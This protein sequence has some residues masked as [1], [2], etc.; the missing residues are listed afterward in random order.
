MLINRENREG[1]QLSGK[2]SSKFFMNA[3]LIAC[4]LCMVTGEGQAGQPQ[5]T[6]FAQRDQAF[7]KRLRMD[8]KGLFSDLEFRCVGPVVM[9]GRVVDVEPVPDEPYSFYVAYATGGL[10]KTENNGMR[11]KPVFEMQNAVSIGDIAV[12]PKCPDTIWVGTGEANSARSHYSGT[13]IFKTTDGGENW[14]CMGLQETH[15]VGRILVHPDDSNIIYVAAMGHLYTE[16]PERGVFKS[17]DGGENW[18]KILYLN[19]KT[20]AIDIIFD[21][22]NPD[23]IY[24]AMWQKVRRAWNIDECGPDSGIYKS[25]DGGENWNKLD[26]FPQNKYIGRIGLAV[27]PGNPKVV[28]AL[29]DNHKPKPQEEQLGKALISV[30]KLALMTRQDVLDVPESEL[31]SFIRRARLPK[32]HTAKEIRR[33]LTED[34]ITVKD[35]YDYLVRLDSEAI[36]PETYGAEVYRSDDKGDSWTKMNLT[37]LDS[38]Y[39]IAG[40]YFGQIR[41]SPD[42]EDRIYIMGVPLLASADG[43]RTY[44]S[45]GKSNVHVDHHAL[46]IDPAHPD[47]IINGNDGG[48]NITYD[49]GETWQKL[50]YVP[51]GQFYAINVDMA[52]PY[53]IY[54]GLQDNGT[55]KG[56]SRSVINESQPWEHISGG[57]GFYIQ[58]A[59]DFT[60]YAGSQWGHY[61]RMDTN[62]RRT[63]VRPDSPRMDEPGLR[64]NWQTPIMLSEHSSNVLY[65]GA[66]RLFRSLDRGENLKPISPVLTEPQQSGNV[67]YGTITTMAESKQTFGLIYV[68]TDDGR[69]HMTDD[70]GIKWKEI[71]KSLPKGLWC[72]RIETS[73]HTDGL[74]YLSLSAYRNDDFT[75]FLYKSNN[76]GKSWKSIKGNLPDESVNVI[77]EDPINPNVLYIGTDMGVFVTLNQGKSWE[78]MQNGMPITPVHDMVVHP[79]DR[80]LVVGTF[81]RSIYVMD[82]EPIQTLT[83]KIKKEK[84]YL[85]EPDRIREYG[86]YYREPSAIVRDS[87]VNPLEIKY[88]LAKKG[89]VN[90]SIKAEDGEIVKKF[91][92]TG[93]AGINML[94]WDLQVDRDVEI[95]RQLD[96]CEKEVAEVQ[97][98]IEKLDSSEQEKNKDDNVAKRKSLVLELEKKKQKLDSIRRVKNEPETYADQPKQ[99]RDNMIQKIYI[100]KGKYTLEIKSG[101]NTHSRE[102]IVGDSSGKS[103]S[104]KLDTVDKRQAETE[105]LL[106]EYLLLEN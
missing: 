3:I 55:Y 92:D 90:I 5:A 70:G 18:Q 25:T 73:A 45:I 78:V 46:W 88:W 67:P 11:F 57:D 9:S 54:G 40:Y 50:N 27:A 94:Q 64:Y 104:R 29:L 48:L 15:H 51:V 65:Y 83:P 30:K 96:K 16:N 74:V 91:K 21:P 89:K 99:T 4:F 17:S 106:K 47:H 71:G 42:D 68:G 52:E 95:E 75:T 19:D 101:K 26:S 86:N 53:N 97:N 76:F 72:T 77:R 13:G 60:V 20:G 41:V 69:V 62:G 23:I 38:M 33:Q 2:N 43:G 44:E 32:V 84:I 58:I 85:F 105:R 63:R 35:L 80:E 10:W 49:G 59:D 6:T 81:G 1:Y 14:Q 102:L 7:T 28:Y 93:R 100:S 24:A 82:I 22:S 12:D 87:R 66:N 103:A 31:E 61:S 79:R 34:E 37:Y 36:I 56:S 8:K 98:K 39:N